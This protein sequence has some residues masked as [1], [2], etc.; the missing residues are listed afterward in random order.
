[1][2][3][4]ASGQ[5]IG[6]GAADV[7]LAMLIVAAMALGGGGSPSPLPEMLLEWCALAIVAAVVWR[8]R[9]P[10]RWPR[11][12]FA[13]AAALLVLPALQLIPLPPALWRSLPGREMEEAALALVSAEDRW[14]PWSVSPPRTLAALLAL[15]VP[16]IA[17][18]L[19]ARASPDGR[20]LT[21]AVILA[22]A[23]L[24]VALGAAQ[25]AGGPH[26]PL[27]FYAPSHVENLTGFQANRNAQ[28]DVLLI[29]LLAL[30]ALL[31]ALPGPVSHRR[32]ALAASA[33][34]VLATGVLLTASRT[35]IALLALEL[36][37]V[38]AWQGRNVLGRAGGLRA[39]VASAVAF[40]GLAGVGWAATG[41]LALGRI[42]ARFAGGDET[43]PELWQD[44]LHAI[45]QHW[46]SGSGIGTF[47]PV[48]YAS[49][50]LEFVD[51]SVPNRAHNDFLELA[52][53]AGLPGLVLLAA[54]GGVLV[55]RMAVSLRRSETS[56]RR[57]QVGFAAGVLALL[58]A[59]SLVDYPLRS[60]AL[61]TLAGVASGMIL[62]PIGRRGRHT[63]PERGESNPT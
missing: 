15:T 39:I 55:W 34:L 31:A 63:R 59:H 23:L 43:R 33:A 6:L 2:P 40:V 48:F 38:F 13:F 49:E 26:S 8:D 22:M 30:A 47:V 9:N 51:R 10:T 57:A 25:L 27:R 17:V 18:V 46:P 52:L 53:E 3:R 37:A 29:G 45:G 35:G 32:A 11:L 58:A 44:T 42:A 1:M 4:T 56:E 24:S 5:R 28:A 7:G 16:A 60:M 50:R 12:A 14:M 62:A 36:M 41:N 54:L 20:R 61:A 21:L 19:A